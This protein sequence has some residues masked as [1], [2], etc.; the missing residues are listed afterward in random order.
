M[1][2]AGD[3]TLAGRGTLQWEPLVHRH[4]ARIVEVRR[5]VGGFT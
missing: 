4:K 1:S 3:I 5:F 2:F